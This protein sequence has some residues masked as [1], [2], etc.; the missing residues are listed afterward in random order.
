MKNEVKFDK[1]PKIN[2]VSNQIAV[3]LM[4]KY[5]GPPKKLT[6]MEQL[7]VSDKIERHFSAQSST[8]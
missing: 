2:K 8:T 5:W 6:Q 1:V 7:K 3:N 4:N